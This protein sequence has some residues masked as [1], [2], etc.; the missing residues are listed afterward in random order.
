MYGSKDGNTAWTRQ[1]LKHLKPA[2]VCLIILPTSILITEQYYEERKRLVSSNYL[3]AVFF[4]FIHK[5]SSTGNAFDNAQL[6]TC[7]LLLRK[8]R[9]DK[10]NIYFINCAGKTKEQ[11]MAEYKSENK[12]KVSRKRLKEHDY[13][14]IKYILERLDEPKGETIGQYFRKVSSR[15]LK[16]VDKTNLAI[17]L[18]TKLF[19]KNREPIAQL[20]KEMENTSGG[21]EHWYLIPKKKKLNEEEI[22]ENKK[23]MR[24]LINYL[25]QNEP[26]MR[27]FY[28]GSVIKELRI[29]EFLEWKVL[30]KE[31]RLVEEIQSIPVEQI[32]T[33]LPEI[34]LINFSPHP[35]MWEINSG[36]MAC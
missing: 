4:D 24:M 2:G 26:T 11:I 33:F 12:E 35:D 6:D 27:R 1:C 31:E 32:E 30:W 23:R 28:Y 17:K 7:V 16:E 15:N 19:E 14:F 3:E 5:D 8:N 20:V 13:C 9:E 21:V 18:A 36:E 29:K 34:E 10:E 22:A 25:E